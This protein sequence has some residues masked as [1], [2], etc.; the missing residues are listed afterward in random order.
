M[1]LIKTKYNR[2]SFL[3]VS[4]A[5]G[6]GMLLGFSWL[7]D[8]RRQRSKKKYKRCLNPDSISMHS[9]ELAITD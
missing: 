7:A 4:G 1:T 2:R 9:F 5:A 3:Q 8:V 6:G